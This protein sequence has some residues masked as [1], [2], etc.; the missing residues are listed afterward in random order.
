MYLG[1]EERIILNDPYDRETE[2][3]VESIADYN[4]DVS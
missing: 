4:A 2:I 1:E 3:A